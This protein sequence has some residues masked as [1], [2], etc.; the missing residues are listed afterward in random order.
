MT[1]E[2]HYDQKHISR[3]EEETVLLGEEFGKRYLLEG[4][5]V[6]VS[7][8]LGAGKTHF[9]KGV[10]GSLGI[11]EREITSPTFTLV[12]EYEIV[13]GR[14][15]STGPSASSGQALRALYHLDCYRFEKAEDLLA[16]G[17]EDY[18]YPKHAATIIEWPERI[19]ALIP[20]SAI[21]VEIR[22]ISEFERSIFIRNLPL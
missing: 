9:I 6:T 4:A 11:D 5:V 8:E 3:S 20:R 7:G 22:V 18:L 12:N 2:D 1:K 19:A 17:V 16:L 21:G 14:A 13:D 15:G 10:A